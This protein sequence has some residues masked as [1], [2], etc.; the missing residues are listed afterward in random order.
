M[1]RGKIA[2]GPETRFRVGP[3]ASWPALALIVAGGAHAETAI[4][5]VGPPTREEIAAACGYVAAIPPADIKDYTIRSGVFD[6]DGDGSFETVLGTESSGTA[7]G[8]DQEILDR[9]GQPVMLMP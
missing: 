9:S 2:D 8:D 4:G 5:Q 7:H 3:L 1:R 6:I